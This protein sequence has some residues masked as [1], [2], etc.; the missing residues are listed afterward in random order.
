MSRFI[1]GDKVYMGRGDKMRTM[2][3]DRVIDN[4]MLPVYQYKFEAPHDGFACGEQ[5]IR[6]TPDGRDLKISECYKDQ[7]EEDVDT[8]Y[9]TIANGFSQ[10]IDATDLGFPQTAFTNL[11]FKPDLIL[12]RWLKEYA[13]GRMIIDVGCGQGHLVR[14]LKMVGAKA[15]GLEPN[16]NYKKYMEMRLL[17]GGNISDSVNEILPMDVQRAAG[18]IQG[19]GDKAMLIFARPC[20]SDFVEVG[21]DIMPNGMEALYITLP[22]QNLELYDDLGKYRDQAVLLDHKG[23]SED[24]EVIYSIKK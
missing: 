17:K 13:N 15:M 12:V 6:A 19:M 4:P 10:K 1:K 2:I 18:L 5:S 9:N 22:Q 11:F 8:H 3:V 21:L 16:F 20:H 7:Y 24:S 14:M 23:I